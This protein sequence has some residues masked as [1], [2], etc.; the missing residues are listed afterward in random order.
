VHSRSSCRR[1]LN[2]FLEEF[3]VEIVVFSRQ[4]Q[5][6]CITLSFIM[7]RETSLYKFKSSHRPYIVHPDRPSCYCNLQHFRLKIW[8]YRPK[9]ERTSRKMASPIPSLPARFHQFSSGASSG[10]DKQAFYRNISKTNNLFMRMLLSM[11]FLV[12][13]SLGIEFGQLP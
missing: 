7:T 2:C 6:C 9:T 13:F 3:F 4:R 12:T 1:V 10:E 8:P 5:F 11:S